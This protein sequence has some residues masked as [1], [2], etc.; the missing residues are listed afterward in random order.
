M[1]EIV[2]VGEVDRVILD[3]IASELEN[4]FGSCRVS[5]FLIAIPEEAYDSGRDQYP[6]SILLGSIVSYSQTSKSDITLGV[7]EVDVYARD[8]NF[9]FGQAHMGGECCLISL[10]RLDP[11]FYGGR[12]DKLYR[13]RA[14]KEAVHEIGHCLGLQHCQDPGCVMVFSN[15]VA[16]VDRKT[17]QFCESCRTMEG[18][19]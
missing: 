14:V 9:V 3:H 4:V 10:H 2:A 18:R 8:L 15:S 1:I 13:E 11:A 17:A 16:E 5:D 6:S 12:D 19:E 7:T